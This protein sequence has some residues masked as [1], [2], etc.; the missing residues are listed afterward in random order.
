MLSYA[1]ECPTDR[2]IRSPSLS[3]SGAKLSIPNGRRSPF[4]AISS[5]EHSLYQ[6][7]NRE[8]EGAVAGFLGAIDALQHLPRPDNQVP[9]PPASLDIPVSEQRPDAYPFS[10][11]Q[12]EPAA[13]VTPR[14][15]QPNTGEAN[16]ASGAPDVNIPDNHRGHPASRNFAH[17]PFDDPHDDAT[18]PIRISAREGAPPTTNPSIPPLRR[19]RLRGVFIVGNGAPIKIDEGIEVHLRDGV[20]GQ[21]DFLM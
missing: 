20:D 16:N 12:Y 9:N 3:I 13:S 10:E 2:S 15:T 14:N 6:V 21:V 19:V 18:A 1:D 17:G 4:V 5:R 11:T 7:R 8:P